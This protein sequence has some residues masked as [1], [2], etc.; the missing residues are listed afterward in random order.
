ML[1]VVLIPLAFVMLIIIVVDDVDVVA[2]LR[3][4]INAFQSILLDVVI[5]SIAAV[6]FRE[7]IYYLIPWPW[8]TFFVYPS[9]VFFGVVV[10]DVVVVVIISS[11]VRI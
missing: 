7:I 11:Y 9:Y 2:A 3:N 5:I 10:L 6:V 4:G 8:H 1:S